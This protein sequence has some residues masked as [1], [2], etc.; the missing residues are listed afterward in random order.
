M[1]YLSIPNPERDGDTLRALAVSFGTNTIVLFHSG[2]M[3]ITIAN[4][5]TEVK[6][7]LLVLATE[8][9]RQAP[10]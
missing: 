3:W 1:V 10:R 5:I 8:I 6:T 2:S 7:Y 4:A 9:P